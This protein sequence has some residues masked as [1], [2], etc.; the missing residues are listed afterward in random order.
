VDHEAVKMLLSDYLDGMLDEDERRQVDEHLEACPSCRKELD[1]LRK[2]VQVLAGLPSVDAPE[3]FVSAV[4]SRLRRRGR[5]RRREETR[6]LLR[7]KVPFET[8]CLLMLLVLAALYIMLYLLPQME[9]TIQTEPNLG[10]KSMSMPRRSMDTPKH[11]Q[12]PPASRSSD[13]PPASMSGPSR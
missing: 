8:I 12:S 9:V 3:G 2:T 6:S 11:L 13:R 7:Q 4:R 1:D 10:V 5:L